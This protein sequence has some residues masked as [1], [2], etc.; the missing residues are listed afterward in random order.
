MKSTGHFTKITWETGK[1]LKIW[2]KVEAKCLLACSPPC[3]ILTKK[4][5]MWVW[6]Q[7]L[8]GL[9]GFIAKKQQ[10]L[11]SLVHW[12]SETGRP[13]SETQLNQ[14]RPQ[15]VV[16]FVSANRPSLEKP[17]IFGGGKMKFQLLP[18]LTHYT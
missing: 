2:E 10:N 18:T 16:W 8:V 5:S 17:D 9:A 12:V 13:G 4:F 14:L 6:S 1:Y 7:V 3:L 11:Y 15:S